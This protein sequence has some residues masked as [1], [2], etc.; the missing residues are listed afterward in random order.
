MP[1]IYNFRLK[2]HLTNGNETDPGL[3]S[4][5][6]LRIFSLLNN[7]LVPEQQA[8]DL[9][10]TD[11]NDAVKI[12]D[13]LKNNLV[14]LKKNI[15]KS[16]IYTASSISSTD[17]TSEFIIAVF[18]LEIYNNNIFDLLNPQLKPDKIN[19][20]H[21]LFGD[22]PKNGDK[23]LNILY[24]KN[25]TYLP[26]SN[27]NETMGVFK[28]AYKN[29]TFDDNG[30]NQNS[31]RGH[32]AIGFKLFN[33][34]SNQSSM[35]CFQDMAGSEGKTPEALANASP[36][37]AKEHSEIHSSLSNLS[38]ALGEKANEKAERNYR[39]GALVQFM[40]WYMEKAVSIKLIVCLSHFSKYKASSSA[41]NLAVV[42]KK[43]VI[44]ETTKCGDTINF[45]V[46]IINYWNCTKFNENRKCQINYSRTRL[47]RTHSGWKKKFE[48]N[49]GL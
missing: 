13:S 43:I 6:A 27:V 7:R 23:N 41:L 18:A 9:M 12:K 3:V 45:K 4:L 47:I 5:T 44:K 36:K 16:I 28:Y 14:N 25:L 48:L 40:S 33:V 26:V 37:V 38:I 35:F 15:L 30:I 39:K 46:F 24:A 32:A 29:L 21:L 34:F 42:S 11:I 49:G 1:I 2:S 8:F 19:R 17:S 10:P 22:F 20:Q 31:S